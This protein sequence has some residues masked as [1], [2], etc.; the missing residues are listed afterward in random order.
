LTKIEPLHDILS[1]TTSTEN[2]ERIL[3]VIR[4]KKQI[5]YKGRQSKSQQISHQKPQKQ[6]GY[7]VRYIFSPR[8]AKLSFNINETLKVFHDK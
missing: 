1:L 8:T 7:G 3:E 5:M 2:R 4:E 6:E